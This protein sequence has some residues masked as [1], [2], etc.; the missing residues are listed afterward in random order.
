MAHSVLIIDDEA[1][2][3]DLLG[4]IFADE[5]YQTHKAAHSEQALAMIKSESIDLIVLD[6]WLE[7]SD[8]DG[9]EILRHLK[10]NTDYNNIP[11]LMISG[12]GNVELAVDAMKIGAFDFIE[13]PFKIDYILLTAERALEQKHLKDENTQLKQQVDNIPL[14]ECIYPSQAMQDLYKKI[15]QN[16]ESDSRVLITG[17]HGT[18]KSR[19]A[20][21]IYDHAKHH[22]NEYQIVH[23]RDLTANNIDAYIS[24]TNSTLLIKSIENLSDE[25][26][27]VLLQILSTSSS[28]QARIFTTACFD[29]KDTFSQ[30]LYDRLSINHYQVPSLSGRIEDIPVI[31]QEFLEKIASDLSISCPSISSDALRLLKVHEW[32]YNIRQL[33][34]AIEWLVLDK[35]ARNNITS[36]SFQILPQDIQA[37]LNSSLM[38]E[39]VNLNEDLVGSSNI[40]RYTNLPLKEA[41]ECFEKEYL[42]RILNEN[43]GNISRMA[44]IVGMDRTAL[45]RKL[46]IMNVSYEQEEEAKLA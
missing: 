27:T 29:N 36:H 15:N 46:K 44:D 4:D 40:E 35:V 12:H 1:D 32:T 5:G 38:Q 6:I 17:T 2:I 21:T 30:A 19:I 41:R 14:T 31:T 24:K 8:M 22:N 20:R 37:L 45:H 34:A 11:V 18:G 42:Q 7:N 25:M 23:A 28:S 13:K 26:Q 39:A 3:R 10:N 43:H 16:M 9:I 33:K